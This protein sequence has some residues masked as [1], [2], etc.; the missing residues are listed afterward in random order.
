LPAQVTRQEKFIQAVRQRRG[1]AERKDR[2]AP[3]KHRH[4]HAR[5]GLV[6]AP[7]VTRAD[8]LQLPMHPVVRSS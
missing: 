1:G 4:G 7:A 5:A 6:I 2:V 3:E 8:F